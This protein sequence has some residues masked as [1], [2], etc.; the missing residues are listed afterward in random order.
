MLHSTETTLLSIHNDLVLAVEHGEVTSLILLDLSGA[1]DTV[2]HSILLHRLRN[3]FGLHGTS[4]DWFPSY[5]TS[6]SQAVSIQNSTSSFS[7]IPRGLLQGSVLDPLLYILYTAPLALPSPRTQSNTT[8]ML[9]TPSYIAYM[10]FF[11]SN[12]TTLLEILSNTFSYILS[13]MN[14]NKLLL[15]PSNTEQG[16][17]QEL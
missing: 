12:T 1:F 11:P 9:M 14:S 7:N 8:S 13:W 4:L 17:S 10:S 16:H 5:L 15:N 2:D 6:C 3:W